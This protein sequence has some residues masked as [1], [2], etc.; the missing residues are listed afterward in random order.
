MKVFFT[1]SQRGKKEFGEY[2]K[3]I[4]QEIKNAGYDVVEDD[5]ASLSVDQFYS[6]LEKG[7]RKTNIEF[8]K[9][10]IQH[11]KEADIIILECSFHSLS[12]GYI[13]EKA[14]ELNKPTIVL[15]LRD[16][17]PYFLEGV[18][19]EKLIIKSYNDKNLARILIEVF[20]LAKERRDKRFNF[21]ISPKLL[22]YLESTSKKYSITKSTFIRNL[23][24]EHKKNQ[25]L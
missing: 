12:I 15:Y 21:F 19:D 11:I 5:L 18:E 13:I 6:K 14:L 2:Y 4:Y 1:A 17:Q 9:K 10:K 23:I 3:K 16:N 20:E 24:L 25:E 8:Y 7:G 22:N